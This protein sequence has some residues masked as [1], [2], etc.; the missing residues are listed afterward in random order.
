MIQGRHPRL[1]VVAQYLGR[2]RQR[3]GRLG[4]DGPMSAS[5]VRSLFN[6]RMPQMS[7]T[8]NESLVISTTSSERILRAKEWPHEPP[9]GSTSF[10]PSRTTSRPRR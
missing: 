7:F 1:D 4:F 10:Q 3:I 6:T 5:M 8:W 2:S 9:P